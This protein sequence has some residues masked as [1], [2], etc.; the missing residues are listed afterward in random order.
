MKRYDIYAYTEL[1]EE[2]D[3][4]GDW[5]KYEDAK[6]LQDLLT[7]WVHVWAYGHCARPEVEELFQRT[8]EAVKDEA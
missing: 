3:C 4:E 5:V 1:H 6:A 7:E 2:E 8:R